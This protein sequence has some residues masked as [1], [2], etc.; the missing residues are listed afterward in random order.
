MPN[1]IRA[2]AFKEKAT[3]DLTSAEYD[4]VDLKEKKRIKK[5]FLRSLLEILKQEHIWETY[6][7]MG[8]GRPIRKIRKIFLSST[9]FQALYKSPIFSLCPHEKS[10]Y[11]SFNFET[12]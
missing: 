1:Q 7:D 11:R 8:R 3:R 2:D 6:S 4:R 9:C 5:P 10:R 12:Q